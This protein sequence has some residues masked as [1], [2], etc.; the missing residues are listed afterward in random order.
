M[1]AALADI[2]AR[3]SSFVVEDAA[4]PVDLIRAGAGTDA[5]ERLAIYR[6]G[7]RLRLLEA[8]GE[9][10]PA[11]KQ[12]LGEE[13]F[14]RMGC[15][16]IAAVRS[17]HYSIRWFG[18]RLGEFLEGDADWRERLGAAAL[19]RW[20]WALGKAADTSDATSIGKEILASIP[21]ER[22]AGMLF[23]FHPSL[24]RIDVTWTA[25]A[26]RQVVESKA[27]TPPALAPLDSQ[28]AWAIWRDGTKILYRS[29]TADEALALDAARAGATFGMLCETLAE[30]QGNGAA[31]AAAG[32]LG[33]WVGCGWI[34]GVEA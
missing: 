8:L 12:F 11:L 9:D 1:T 31:R 2:Q 28:V 27:P 5:G 10:Y 21:P 23:S 7:Y 18:G 20:E 14:D 29:L 26:F 32:F 24:G 34:V 15:A 4:A 13:E 25:P 3:L 16:Y 17:R 19:A 30:I 6:D 33:A 22:W